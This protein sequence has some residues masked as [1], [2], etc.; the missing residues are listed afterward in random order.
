MFQG[1]PEQEKC[2]V[3]RHAH[4]KRTSPLQFLRR[5]LRPQPDGLVAG[6][7]C[8][9]WGVPQTIPL[10]IRRWFISLIFRKLPQL[11]FGAVPQSISPQVAED[12]NLGHAGGTGY[13]ILCCASKHP[14]PLCGDGSPKTALRKL[15][16][17]FAVG[18]TCRKRFFSRLP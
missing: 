11:C 10:N 5:A 3:P 18:K 16:S 2:R 8:F 7:P 13:K 17:S 9:P 6:V 1:T 15:T 14:V 12:R 4:L